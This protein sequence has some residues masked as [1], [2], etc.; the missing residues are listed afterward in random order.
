MDTLSNY[1]QYAQRKWC[2]FENV[3]SSEYIYQFILQFLFNDETAS[4]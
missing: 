2:S 3:F 1:S 4:Y